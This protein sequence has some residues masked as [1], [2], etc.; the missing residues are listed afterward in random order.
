MKP[1]IKEINGNPLSIYDG[2]NDENGVMFDHAGNLIISNQ[3]QI[4]V[5]S[6]SRF[7]MES[8]TVDIRVS[9]YAAIQDCLN[10]T[11]SLASCGINISSANV[12][13]I[14][15]QIEDIRLYGRRVYFDE[16]GYLRGE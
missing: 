8:C 2:C 6:P 15:S 14:H 10:N 3:E 4:K 13:N 9:E 7:S 1:A 11:I 5:I 12:V 16:S